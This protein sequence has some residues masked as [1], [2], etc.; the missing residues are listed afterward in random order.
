M[1]FCVTLALNVMVLDVAPTTFVKDT[2][3]LV[4]SCH[5]TV[6][7]GD[8]I[9]AA[10][11]VTVAPSVT[12][13]FAGFRVTIG[14]VI[15][16]KIAA[17]VVAVPDPFVNTARYLFPFCVLLTTKIRVGAIAPGMLANVTPLSVLTCHCT[18]GLGAPLA[19]AVNVA[20]VP[21]FTAWLAGCSVTTGALSPL[22][23]VVVASA[24]DFAGSVFPTL[25]V[26]M[27]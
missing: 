22:D 23:T 5:C 12:V 26:A 4:L 14:G 17:V 6:G 10:T 24:V 9:A 27:L 3:L 20:L 7:I 1:P 2:P 25:S 13:S 15:T 18:V 11:N 19:A 16:V 21:V 8:P